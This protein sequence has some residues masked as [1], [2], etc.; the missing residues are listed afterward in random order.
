MMTARGKSPKYITQKLS[1]GFEYEGAQYEPI[2]FS[3]FQSGLATVNS[4]VQAKGDPSKKKS[5]DPAQ[6]LTRFQEQQKQESEVT[7]EQQQEIDFNTWRQGVSSDRM[8]SSFKSFQS[9]L[10]SQ[11][12]EDS[13]ASTS[14]QKDLP[15]VSD[16]P[17]NVKPSEESSLGPSI[18]VDPSIESKASSTEGYAL[19]PGS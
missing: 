1:A 18:Y 17:L 7:P 11:S 10:A 3:S 4:V 19:T 16:L 9:S 14:D 2:N 12:Q 15:A 6:P 8:G 13:Q 5:Q